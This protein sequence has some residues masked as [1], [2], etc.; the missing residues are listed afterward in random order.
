VLPELGETEAAILLSPP[1][2]VSFF[3][4]SPNRAG[5]TRNVVEI[6]DVAPSLSVTSKVTEYSPGYAVKLIEGR[7]L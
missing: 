5:P 1:Q 3:P 6:S 7:E 2:E 4:G